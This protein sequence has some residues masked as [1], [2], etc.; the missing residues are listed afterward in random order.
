MASRPR[1]SRGRVVPGPRATSD[2]P[3]ADHAP[4]HR[5]PR[6]R[7]RRRERS[8]THRPVRRRAPGAR[9]GPPLPQRARPPARH[10]PLGHPPPLRGDEV[11]HR[12]GGVGVSGAGGDRRRHVGRRLRPRRQG[13][14]PAQQ[15][16]PLSGRAHRG[17]DRGRHVARPPRADLRDHRAAIPPVQ[18]RLSAPRDG[19]RRLA[20]PR[21]GRDAPDDAR[22]LRLAPHR[23]TRRRADR[24]LD[25]PALRPP[26]RRVVGRAVQGTRPA[27][28]HPPRPDRPG[29]GPRPL[30]EVGG[31]GTQ[32]Q[33]RIDGDRP[34]HARHR[35]RRGRRARHRLI[36]GLDEAGLVL[37]QLGDVV[38]AGRRDARAR[39]QRRDAQVQLHQRRRRRR[40]DAT[41]EEHHGP[42]ARAGVPPP[43]ERARTARTPRTT[44]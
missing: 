19:P 12:Q 21:G 17:D 9:R 7:P 37:P 31:R 23:P 32:N 11:G 3:D 29:D 16:R 13:R 22:P 27:V 34:G 20:D 39:H 10:D 38:A 35:Q 30:A 5:L 36:R 1:R 8:R 2:P 26:P 33:P 40:D 28:P 4:D 18:H 25:H 44:S 24:R 14:C 6:P 42:L 41:P 43:L 15:P